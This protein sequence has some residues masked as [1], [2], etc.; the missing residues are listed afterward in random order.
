MREDVI[1]IL[2]SSEVPLSEIEINE[3]MSNDV[4]LKDLCETL[5]DME[6]CD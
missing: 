2:K 4:N 1:K 3:K 5:R 6:K